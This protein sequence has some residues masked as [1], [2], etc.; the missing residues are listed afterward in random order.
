M[1]SIR[2]RLVAM[3]I[4][5]LLVGVLAFFAR[6]FGSLEQLVENESRLR[7]FVSRY[8][9]RSWFFGLAIYTAFSLVPGTVG[10]AVIFGWIFGFWQA[11][12][13]V[14]ISLTVAAIAIFS[15]SRYI[16]RESVYAR[17][18]DQVSKLDQLLDQDGWYY[19]LMLRMAHVPFSFVNYCAAPTS[20]KLSTFAWTTAIGLLPGTAIFV[21][22]GTRIP[23]LATLHEN[24]IWQ[25]VDPLLFAMLSGTIVFP[26][27]IR[28]AI[29]RFR[30][31]L[32]A[33]LEIELNDFDT[34][35]FW[36][37]KRQ[38]NGPG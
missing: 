4:F 31:H 18:G 7:E 28:W 27:L 11:L 33:P 15:L 25:L 22:V 35:R 12:L 21:F 36:P 23:T 1:K 14:D 13:M 24:G 16:A 29:R 9:G 37:R 20:L 8:P 30:R 6:Q 19:M 10:K 32:G 5:I 17:F 2:N 34:P 38:T 3:M 26:V